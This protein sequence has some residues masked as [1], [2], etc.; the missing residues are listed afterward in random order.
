MFGDQGA[1]TSVTGPLGAPVTPDE[2]TVVAALLKQAREAQGLSQE[3]LAER[4]HMGLQQVQA[5]ELAD[6]SSL[7]EPVFV[8]AQA[9]RVAD[10]LGL[11]SSSQIDQL[12]RCE[13]FSTAGPV[14]KPEAFAKQAAR[15]AQPLT[16][17]EA[18][19]GPH[20]PAPSPSIT[21]W[22]WRRALLVLGVVAGGVVVVVVGQRLAETR[23]T[24]RPV[25]ASGA[26]LAALVPRPPAAK[27]RP[28][29]MAELLL[30][31]RQPS[32][33]EVR[34]ERGGAV[35]FRGLLQGERRFP[36]DQGLRVLAGRPDLV[37]VSRA[38]QGPQT[39]G[40][41]SAVRWV[42]FTPVVPSP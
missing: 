21:P 42:R 40:P 25:P 10:A 12:R 37:Q 26:Q 6:G 41:I 27:P 13:A 35:L 20:R 29:A 11:E 3:A 34:R 28:T 1:S 36:L 39:L 2:L 17:A 9:R 16:R 14:L 33:I 31:T 30:A 15:T 7:P 19:A 5:L 32:W 23:A 18:A 8:I 38:G 4:L 24:V 22:P